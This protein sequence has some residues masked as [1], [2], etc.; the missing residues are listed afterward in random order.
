MYVVVSG[1]ADFLV[2]GR[3]LDVMREGD[4][5]GHMSLVTGE[6]P[7]ATIRAQGGHGV[8]LARSRDRRSRSWA[9]RAGS[10]FITE[11]LRRRYNDVAD[12]ARSQP[13]RTADMSVWLVAAS[14]STHL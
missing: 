1:S 13:I 6:E 3:A 2:D 14:S 12:A 7:V 10:R 4:V 11:S 8:P 5:F 9:R